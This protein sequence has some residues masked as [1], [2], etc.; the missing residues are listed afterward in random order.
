MT[1][2][3][4]SCQGCDRD[5]LTL[6]RNGR[7]RSHAANGK[8]VGPDNPACPEGSNFPVQS[9]EF[10]THRFEYGDD[11]IHMAGSFCTVD[12]CGMAEPAEKQVQETL[13]AP[14]N[15]FRDPLPGG[16]WDNVPSPAT[17]RDAL[18]APDDVVMAAEDVLDRAQPG[19]QEPRPAGPT[20]AADFLDGA[21]DDDYA[22]PAADGGRP[23]WPSRYDG[24]CANCFA[25]FDAGE[26]IRRCDEG[27]DY[28]D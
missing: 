20:S 17:V 7:V 11:G 21:D 10:H 6:T 19:Q 18:N 2:Q 26:L 12:D 24:E 14:P 25:H 1:D 28:D 4:Y 9:T 15:Q 8:R 13:P 16:I 23:Y 22:E 3:K 5:D 27:A